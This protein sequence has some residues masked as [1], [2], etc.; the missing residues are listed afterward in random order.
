MPRSR[1]TRGCKERKQRWN[2]APPLPASPTL[3]TRAGTPASSAVWR[4]FSRPPLQSPLRQPPSSNLNYPIYSQGAE[5]GLVA[6]VW[7][8]IAGLTLDFP[9]LE[10]FCSGEKAPA[11]GGSWLQAPPSTSHSASLPTY[12]HNVAHSGNTYCHSAVS[13]NIH[14]HLILGHLILMSPYGTS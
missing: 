5:R 4:R 1:V 9:F 3:T 13:R 10:K 8:C 6:S 2:T 11:F 14:T 7:I 12:C